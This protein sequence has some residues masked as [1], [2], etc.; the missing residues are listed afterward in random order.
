MKIHICHIHQSHINLWD[1][2]DYLLMIMIQMPTKANDEYKNVNIVNF[3][4]YGKIR[5]NSLIQSE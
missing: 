5:L 4:Y 2:G 3:V 1:N